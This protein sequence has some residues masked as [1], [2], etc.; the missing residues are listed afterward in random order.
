MKMKKKYTQSKY[1]GNELLN[2]GG[3]DV[4]LTDILVTNPNKTI[5]E[6]KNKK[7]GMGYMLTKLKSME[8]Y[9]LN[10]LFFEQNISK[11]PNY[12]TI[13]NFIKNLE[14]LVQLYE[15]YYIIDE[16]DALFTISLCL[17]KLLCHTFITKNETKYNIKDFYIQNRKIIYCFNID[18]NEITTTQHG[19][20]KKKK[21]DNYGRKTRLYCVKNNKNKI[22]GEIF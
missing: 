7:E 19:L 14:Q 16:L 18:V 21:K 13:S 15:F 3:F 9:F 6:E 1:F 4:K 12:M 8:S 20:L 10:Q 22:H 11:T 2:I 17:Y 5:K